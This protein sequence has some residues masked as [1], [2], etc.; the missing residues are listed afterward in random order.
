MK[1]TI[2]Y[3]AATAI[4]LWT[5]G[6]LAPAYAQQN[7]GNLADNASG[8]VGNFINLLGLLA[9]LIGITLVVVSI[10]KFKGYSNNAQ[11]PNNKLGGAIGFGLAGLSMIA[12]PEFAGVGVFSLFGDG[13]NEVTLNPLTAP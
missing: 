6:V 12:L 5:A 10:L 4:G 1:V 13:S 3:A 7:F 11:D 9:T 8:Q 2:R